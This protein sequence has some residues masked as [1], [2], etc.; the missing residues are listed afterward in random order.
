MY[1][2]IFYNVL[3]RTCIF[4]SLCILSAGRRR[5]SRLIES[6]WVFNW[7]KRQPVFIN[8]VEDENIKSMTKMR[9]E[10]NSGNQNKRG[11][12]GADRSRILE[13]SDSILHCCCSYLIL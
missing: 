2:V 3:H 7:P 4:S 8:L 6:P 9:V 11:G 5:S 13:T 1:R 12:L 10:K